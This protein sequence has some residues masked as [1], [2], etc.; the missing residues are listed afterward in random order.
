M[1]YES[2]IYCQ[3]HNPGRQ[4]VTKLLYLYVYRNNELIISVVFLVTKSVGVG[5]VITTVYTTELY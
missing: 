4:Q 2:Q 3:E 1:F 5:V